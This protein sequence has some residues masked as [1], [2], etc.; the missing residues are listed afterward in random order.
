MAD[1]QRC[2]HQH[3]SPTKDLCLLHGHVGAQPNGATG[4]KWGFLSPLWYCALCW[5][6]H[7]L[8]QHCH[9]SCLGQGQG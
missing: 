2:P 4:M 8:P 3:C 1:S 5:E 9:Q 7:D 6:I